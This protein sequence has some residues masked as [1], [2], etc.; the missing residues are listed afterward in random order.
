MS[1]VQKRGYGFVDDTDQSLKSKSGG[2]FGLNGKE[3]FLFKFELNPN[4]GADGALGDALDVSFNIKEKSFN[5]RIYPVTKVYDAKNQEITDVNSKEYI[6]GFNTELTQKNAVIVHILKAVG[7]TEAQIKTALGQPMEDFAA[8]INALV[9]LL[10]ANFNTIPLDLFLE[11]QWEI[12]S[13]QDRTFLQIPKNMKG[14]YFVCPAQDGTWT[15]VLSEGKLTYTN[16]TGQVHPFD[17][18]KNFMESNKAKLQQA[19]QEASNAT[20][21]NAAGVA[22]GGEPKSGTW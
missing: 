5:L 2:K 8:F 10:P 7:V 4:A 16:A 17:R 13:G 14:G 18:D 6:T 3:A 15:E 12:P 20:L 11:Y 1:D 22:G 19:G 9:T 21:A